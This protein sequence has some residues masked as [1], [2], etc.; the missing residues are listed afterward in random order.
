MKLTYLLNSVSFTR[1]F[2]NI[3]RQVWRRNGQRQENDSEHSFQLALVAW[4]VIEKEKLDL[5]ISVV[6]KFSLVHDLLE[7]YTGDFSSFSSEHKNKKK[8]EK[9]ALET[10]KKEFSENREIY[11][12]IEI[13]ERRESPEANFVYALDKLLPILNIYLDDGYSWEKNDLSL[14]EIIENKK[15]KVVSHPL[16]AEYF[17]SIVKILSEKEEFFFQFKFKD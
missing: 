11:S 14:L 16:I 15:D 9:T 10:L 1:S 5:D 12:L 7:R 17:E 2:E 8:G 6:V 4:M 3:K 13:Y